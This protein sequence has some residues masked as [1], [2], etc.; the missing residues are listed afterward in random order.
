MKCVQ[1][2]IETNDDSTLCSN[3]IKELLY[4][5]NFIN[6]RYNNSFRSTNINDRLK[7]LAEE[8]QIISPYILKKKCEVCYN[9]NIKLIIHHIMYN[10]PKVITMCKKCHGLLHSNIIGKK[11]R[12]GWR[13]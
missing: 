12:N 5:G 10:P 13:N 7:Q 2:N 11:V 6:V 1:C 9:N 3:D 8:Q 4:G